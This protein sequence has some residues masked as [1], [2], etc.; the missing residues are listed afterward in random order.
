MKDTGTVQRV[1]RYIEAHLGEA[2][3]LDT[4]AGQAGYSKFHLNRLF[5]EGV[6]CTIYKY[7]Q[8]RRITEAARLLAET[9]VPIAD[10]ALE[11]GYQSQQAFHHA[12][13]Q[14]YRTSPQSYRAL[15]VF[16]PERLP[17]TG[18]T[19]GAMRMEGRAA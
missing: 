1:A 3:D 16:R 8:T 7:I 2:L 9:D 5:S 11:A 6:G 18:G 12:F 10:I 13:R 19:G 17:F 14:I 4:I 15:G